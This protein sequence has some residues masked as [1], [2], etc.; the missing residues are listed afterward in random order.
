MAAGGSPGGRAGA[1]RSAAGAVRSGAGPGL[2]AP[3]AAPPLGVSSYHFSSSSNLEWKRVIEGKSR[4][5]GGFSEPCIQ[6][7]KKINTPRSP[8][9]PSPPAPHTRTH[10]RTPRGT[11]AAPRSPAGHQAQGIRL[12]G[13]FGSGEIYW[14]SRIIYLQTERSSV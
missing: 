2:P 4:V 14:I 7:P 13:N 8:R 11:V 1:V 6:E 5:L 9:F 3:F 10:T 12:E